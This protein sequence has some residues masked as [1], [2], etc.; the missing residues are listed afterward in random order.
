MVLH[1]QF[2]CQI[3]NVFFLSLQ[4]CYFNNIGKYSSAKNSGI[5]GLVLSVSGAVT[6]VAI[7]LI[8]I[9][10]AVLLTGGAA[11]KYT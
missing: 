10:I 11:A 6:G 2:V 5:T 3:H 4:A 8:V 1:S 7:L 9:P